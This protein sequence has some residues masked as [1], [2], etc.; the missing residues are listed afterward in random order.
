MYLLGVP[1]PSAGGRSRSNWW[2][3]DSASSESLRSTRR[4]G[5]RL[6]YRQAKFWEDEHLGG[7]VSDCS[8]KATVTAYL[9]REKGG[10]MPTDMGNPFCTD[11]CE[12]PGASKERSLSTLDITRYLKLSGSLY[13]GQNEGQWLVMPAKRFIPRVESLIGSRSEKA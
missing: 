4:N 9:D 13:D 12:L 6:R 3:E 2:E 7:P 5:A 11:S 10:V 1:E 8:R